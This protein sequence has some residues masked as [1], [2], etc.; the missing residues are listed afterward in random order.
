[1]RLLVLRLFA[2]SGIHHGG[3]CGQSQRDAACRHEDIGLIARL[4]HYTID[5]RTAIAATVRVPGESPCVLLP[6]QVSIRHIF[7]NMAVSSS[8]PPGTRRHKHLH[9]GFL[10]MPFLMQP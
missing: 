9:G 8:H 10:L 2:P 7:D 5:D 4:G 6:H 3:N 1:M